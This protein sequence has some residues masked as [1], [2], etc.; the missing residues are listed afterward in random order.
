[1]PKPTSAAKS[2]GEPALAH[3]IRV[4]IVTMDTHLATATAR[5]RARLMRQ[6]PG[7]RLTMF[8]ASEWANDDQLLGN[9][10]AEIGQ[11]DIVVVTMLFLEEHFLPILPA[12][13]ARRAQCDAMV[14]AMSAAEVVRLTR[15]GKFDMG[16]PASGLTA[17]LKRLRGNKDKTS[18]GGQ[19]QMK[20]L[21][22][23]PKLLRFIP[24]TA[25]DVRSYFLALQYW[26]G[27]SEENML[28]MVRFLVNRYA[29]GPR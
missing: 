1:M 29:S 7:L 22:R 28:N 26:L 17:L 8:A 12:L 15:I 3:P 23:V 11:A 25:Q 19:A 10:I 18:T 24:G 27:G 6:L 14:C 13:Q 16:K 9:C 21:R 4:A 5:A 20:M 2:S